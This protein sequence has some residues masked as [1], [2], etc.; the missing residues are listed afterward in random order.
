MSVSFKDLPS[1]A[2]KLAIYEP[3]SSIYDK[4]PWPPKV[5]TEYVKTAKESLG[6]L[7]SFIDFLVVISLMVFIKCLKKSQKLYLAKFKSQ[8]IEL[9]DFTIEM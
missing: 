8:T 7:V 6:V 2:K 1:K 9:D 5:T 4:M 3:G